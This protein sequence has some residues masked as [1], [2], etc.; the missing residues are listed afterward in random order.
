M[1]F[2]PVIAVV[3]KDISCQLC[4][5][6]GSPSSRN[7]SW[8]AVVDNVSPLEVSLVSE[9]YAGFIMPENTFNPNNRQIYEKPVAVSCE[10]LLQDPP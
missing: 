6:Y 5:S 9:T 3:I 7:S 2:Q 10:T 4:S 1:G 8:I